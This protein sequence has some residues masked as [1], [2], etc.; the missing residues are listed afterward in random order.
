MPSQPVSQLGRYQIE[1][2]LG[3]GAFADAYK[4][5]DPMLK[6]TVALKVLKPALVADSE[7]FGR[8][9][10]EA[11]VAANLFHP[12]IA[13][14]LDM[15]EADGRYFIAM[16][17]VDGPSL[18][19]L[20]AANG[21]LPWAQALEITAQIGAALDFA[22]QKGLVHR[23]VKPQNIIISAT[24]GAVLTDFGLVRAIA[25][26]SLTTTGSFLGTPHYMA[27]EIWEGEDAVPATDQYALACVLVEM[28]TGRV[29]FDGKTPPAVMTK[30]FKPLMLPAAWP[31]D[32]PAGIDTALGRALAKTPEER[33]ENN[34]AFLAALRHSSESERKAQAEAA[35]KA[36]LLE[37]QRK[38]AEEQARQEAEHKAQAEATEKARLLEEQRQQVEEQAR[39][40]AERKTQAEAAEKARL[41]EHRELILD[42]GDGVKMEFVR[43]PA[44]EFWM[45]SDKS[46]DKQANDD[47]MPRH[48]V[49]LDE[50]LMGKT[51][52][53]NRQ[54]QV[55]VQKARHRAPSHWKSG[56]IPAGLENH[57]VVQVS[58]EDAATFCK[59]VSGAVGQS[60][61]LPSEAEWEKAARWKWQGEGEALLYPWGNQKP[62]ENLCNYGNNAGKTTP[63]GKYSPH[64]DSPYGCVDMA[65]NVWEWCADWYSADYYKNA[66]AK[67]PPGPPSWHYRVLRGGSW[68]LSDD[69]V[70]SAN[71]GRNSPTDTF[72]IYGFR[73]ARSH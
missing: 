34:N 35:E 27:P 39:K 58:W 25:S 2:H 12:N 49:Y 15:G 30:H 57:P 23:D 6:R 65:G 4:A 45:G 37:E 71:R 73:C 31:Q 24:E 43:V 13:T 68:G 67:N 72:N 51:P 11:Q 56:K 62:T 48:K 42:L 7:A 26:S 10:Q 59:W 54:Y 18:D 33:F 8:F 36:R 5:S 21:P 29:L 20:L 17:F 52:V 66:P 41:L 44:G 64:G 32:V 55:F 47:E 53:T 28:L 16:R 1:S 3:S 63:V 14:V 22:H 69:N 70:R 40:D 60:V 61:R 50:Y 46:I 9:V 38:K 19:K